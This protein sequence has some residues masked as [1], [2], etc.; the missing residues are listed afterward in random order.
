[1]IF[2]AKPPDEQSAQAGAVRL[3]SPLT[4]SGLK[5]NFLE[6]MAANG[7]VLQP[8]FFSADDADAPVVGS[9]HQ[10]SKFKGAFQ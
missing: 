3:L 6:K 10:A 5:P 8:T 2:I 4:C 7:V 9:G 1:D